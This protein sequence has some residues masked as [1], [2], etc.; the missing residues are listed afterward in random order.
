ML[1][2]I[3]IK[4]INSIKSCE[5][6]FDKG[7]FEYGQNNIFDD[8]VNPIAIYGLNGSG[9]TSFFSAIEQFN[10]LMFNPPEFL[11]PFVVNNILFLKYLHKK[12]NDVSHISGSIEFF[13]EINGKEFDYFI[14]TTRDKIFYIS[15]EKLS[16]DGKNIFDKHADLV[17]VQKTYLT[18]SPLIPHLRKLVANKI[19]DADIQLVYT[20]LCSFVNVNLN[21]NVVANPKPIVA[22]P[23][24][25]GANL[26][27]LLVDK[28]SEIKETLKEYKDFPIY[29]FHK[30]A[31]T[32][33][34]NGN[35]LNYTINIEDGDF[36]FDLPLNMISSGMLNMSLL[37]CILLA[38]PEG[39]TLFIDEMDKALHPTAIRSFIEIAQKRK[40]QLVF[41]SHNTNIMQYLRPDQIY[42]AKWRK[43]FS[44]YYRL[45]EIYPNIRSVN[46]I[47]KMYL[48]CVFDETLDNVD[49]DK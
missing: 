8:V 6:N 43:G 9:K 26:F 21:T 12:S 38:V 22:S 49:H 33:I 16:I 31:K 5:L 44:N 15:H 42:F 23:I 41:S 17:T 30:Q 27:D 36:N 37:L 29:T 11:A 20:Y 25:S 39:A 1:K 35:V 2:K 3:I 32:P 48:N 40:I 45:S 14:Q 13:L 28:S 34:A 7:K 19:T 18:Q 4:N 24:F 46:N 47:E 10:M